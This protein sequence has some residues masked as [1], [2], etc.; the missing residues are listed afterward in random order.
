MPDDAPPAQSKNIVLLSDGTGSSGGEGLCTNV[1]RTYLAIERHP[2]AGREQLAFYDDGVG[3]EDF[4]L[5]RALGGAVG[6]GLGRNIRQLYTALA[7]NYVPGDQ[8]YVLGFSRGAYTVRLLAGLICRFGVI[9]AARLSPDRLEK[10]VSDAY[11]LYHRGEDEHITAF[12]CE[13]CHAGETR[14]RF[15]GVWDTVDAVGVPF[16]WMRNWIDRIFK[17]RFGDYKLS[18]R[19]DKGCHAISIDDARIT[20]HAELWDERDESCAEGAEPRIEQLW[21]AGV[22][23]NVGGGYPKDQLALVALGWMWAKASSC[24][25]RLYQADCEEHGRRADPTGK[26]YDSRA[27]RAAFYRYGP[28]HIDELCADFG[29]RQ[30]RLH[31]SV[32]QRLRCAGDSYLPANLS[33]CVV[34]ESGQ[35]IELPDLSAEVRAVHRRRRAGYWLSWLASLSALWL[36]GLPLLIHIWSGD[37]AALWRGLASDTLYNLL[38]IGGHGAIFALL[39]ALR[40]RSKSELRRIGERLW[41]PLLARDPDA[42][43][44]GGR[45]VASAD[46]DDSA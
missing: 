23:A 33:G 11:Q 32:L 2:A 7:R 20:F 44:A 40:Q 28:R 41:Q 35:R 6:W 25:L 46:A 43:A 38:L 1:W 29:L 42:A 31:D 22:H 24:G 45:S 14:V 30:V 16:D 8:I 15:V 36:L 12:Q 13:H 18:P 27:G 3:T 34:S 17:Y 26:L 19:V 39:T 10:L 21:F 5:F 37:F 9:D 4:K